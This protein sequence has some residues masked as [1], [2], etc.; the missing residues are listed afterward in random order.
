LADADITL[1]VGD[2]APDLLATLNDPSGAPLLRELAASD[3]AQVRLVAAEALAPRA[4][5]AWQALVRSLTQAPESDVR[6][7]AAR[8]AASFDPEL[9]SRVLGTLALDANQAMSQEATRILAREVARD[10]A[11][12]RALLRHPDRLTRVGAAS[13]VVRLTN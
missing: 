6:L 7:A 13:T 3:S 4:D 11:T 1:G 9:A 5:A 2:T 8:L 10:L 12:L